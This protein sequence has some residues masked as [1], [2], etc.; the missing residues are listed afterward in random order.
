MVQ[1][2]FNAMGS[3]T[4]QFWHEVGLLINENPADFMERSKEA[5]EAL[6][7]RVMTSKKCP[8]GRYMCIYA[9]ISVC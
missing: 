3:I 7:Q 6:I 2:G 9:G 5:L 8:R 4:F 1:A